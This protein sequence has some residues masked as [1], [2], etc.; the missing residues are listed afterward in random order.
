MATLRQLRI[1]ITVA[2]TLH[3]SEAA[4]RLYLSQPTVSQTV[5]ELE[6][7]FDAV[8]FER[9]S[10]YLRLT[11]KGATFREYA[12]QVV[13]SYDRLNSTMKDV[14]PIRELRVGATITIGNTMLAEILENMRQLYPDI[15]PRL[16]VENT[17]RLENRLLH[18][19]VDIALIEGIVTN[20]K[21]AKL[22]LAEDALEVICARAHPLW[23]RKQVEAGALRNQD[24][25][26]REQGSGTRT[27][28]ENYMRSAQI[29]IR[30]AAESTSSTA[31]VELVMHNLGLGVLSRRCVR[32]YTSENR[33][34]SCTIQDMPMNRF[35]HVCYHVKHPVS[36]QMRDFVQAA[37][38]TVEEMDRGA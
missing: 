21:I 28:F 22:P 3:M 17:Q 13:D 37:R 20:D 1:F 5:S 38:Q 35:F 11:A 26:L 6:K 33:I 27:V 12:Q 2:E 30:V 8:F 4:R 10:K 14:R 23:G 32:R 9:T 29:P 31:I 34:W 25:I 16:L 36:S 18:N 24:F 19:E 15:R 7:E